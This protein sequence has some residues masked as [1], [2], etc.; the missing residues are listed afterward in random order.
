MHFFHMR[1]IL[2]CFILYS[3][4]LKSSSSESTPESADSSTTLV[5]VYGLADSPMIFNGLSNSCEKSKI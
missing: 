3:F 5:I 1:Y 4:S 2:Y